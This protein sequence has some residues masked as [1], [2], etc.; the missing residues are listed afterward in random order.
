MPRCQWCRQESATADV[1]EW[2]K[3]P[4]TPGWTPVVAV[5]PAAATAAVPADRMTFVQNDDSGNNDR[6]LMYSMV[7][8]V[9]LTGLVWGFN[10]LNKKDIAPAPAPPPV[11][12]P[13]QASSPNG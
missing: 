10:Y 6:I 7:G 8:I 2:C 5:G 1:C 3:R 9:I 11:Y 12:A 13:Q 4:L